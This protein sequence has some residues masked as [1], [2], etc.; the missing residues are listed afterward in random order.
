MRSFS[1]CDNPVL[2]ISAVSFLSCTKTVFFVTDRKC[3]FYPYAATM[4]VLTMF[5]PT[6]WGAGDK[7]HTPSCSIQ[8]V[9]KLVSSGGSS[10]GLSWTRR[11]QLTLQSAPLHR[12]PPKPPS[13]RRHLP[14]HCHTLALSCLQPPLSFH[15][16]LGG[17]SKGQRSRGSVVC[18]ETVACVGTIRQ[19]T[20]RQLCLLGGQ[21]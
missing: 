13:Q 11:P 5:G 6:F 21:L 9:R 16:S 19:S 12:R 18:T 8:Y 1:R 17:V 15:P 4:I 2:L 7:L 14:Y 10:S 20:E 3:I